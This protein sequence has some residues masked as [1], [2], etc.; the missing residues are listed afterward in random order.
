M[1]IFG[2]RKFYIDI[3]LS[4]PGTDLSDEFEGLCKD[5]ARKHGLEYATGILDN[6]YQW[7]IIQEERK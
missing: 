2:K 6:R 4:Q 1:V 3:R 5:F 7:V